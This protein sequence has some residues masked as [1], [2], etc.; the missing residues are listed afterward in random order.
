MDT[1]ERTDPPANALPAAFL[2]LPVAV[3]VLD[4]DLRFVAI[5]D[6]LAAM[7]GLPPE[8]HIG[9]RGPD[10]LPGLDPGAWTTIRGVVETGIPASF[11]LSGTTPAGG[12]ARVWQEQYHPWRERA[13]GDILGV[14]ATVIDVTDQRVVE[15]T[16]RRR[17]EQIRGLAML[18][19]ELV[20]VGAEIDVAELL[21]R[22]AVE[23]FD[24][25]AAA[26]A[27]GP[28]GEP[29]R[30]LASVG[31]PADEELAQLGHGTALADTARTGRPH[32]LVAGPEWDELFPVGAASHRR[33]EL[34]A[35]VTVPLLSADETIG[36][37]GVS[38]AEPRL[39]TEDESATLATLAA[40]GSQAMERA[41]RAEERRRADELRDAFI[42][43]MAHELKTPIATIYGGLQT[44]ASHA[45][46]APESRDELL[47][48][49]ISEAD[50]LV[51]LVD[52]LVAVS[53]LE[54]G[55]D[56][57]LSEPLLVS[58]LTRRVVA[59][60]TKGSRFDVSVAIPAGVPP[61]RGEAAYV[62]QVLRN[63]LT[64]ARK[65]GQPPYEVIVG[66]HEDEVEVRVLDRGAGLPDDVDPLFD[67]YY[68]A[69]SA[70]RRASGSGIGLFVCRE[71][72]RLMGGRTWA[73]NRE[74]GG[75]E[76]GFALPTWRDEDV[77][78]RAG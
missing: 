52:D 4:R 15:A 62:E 3:C 2:E 31:Y 70:S 49:A 48:N 75:A 76:F 72:V 19:A 34:A 67:L 20:D 63:F 69:P 55:V 7:N 51:R 29:I 60:A 11:L 39:P 22:H 32:S 6:A 73:S 40:V 26:V 64:N 35:T 46:L 54:R 71:L 25:S 59:A 18:G 43:V 66:H 53:R 24:A 61:V 36:A 58:H 27:V 28:R 1:Q 45:S 12:E 78:P 38:Y 13:S 50:R 23:L 5:N 9:R 37:L 17:A 41:R 65:Y 68:R 77:P 30:V 33:L 56:V 74:G 21:C 47:G 8:A 44:I 16:A 42:D 10:L 57:D 14:I